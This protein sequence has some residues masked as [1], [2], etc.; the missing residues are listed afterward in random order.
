M[1]AYALSGDRI[2]AIKVYDEWAERLRH[3]VRATPGRAVE[4][5]ANRLRREGGSGQRRSR[6]CRAVH[7]EQWRNQHFV[8]RSAS[9]AG[10][11]SSGT[12]Q[13]R[14]DSATF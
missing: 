3:E 10:S 2:T 11:M 4:D 6:Q 8:G 14:G 9:I 7:T 12:Q 13:A 1:E 5:L